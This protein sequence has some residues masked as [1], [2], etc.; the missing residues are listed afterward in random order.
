M[1]HNKPLLN[2]LGKGILYEPRYATEIKHKTYFVLYLLPFCITSQIHGILHV[3]FYKH[4]SVFHSL[5]LCG[6]LIPD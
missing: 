6:L 2:D 3:F 1:S 5:L 4:S